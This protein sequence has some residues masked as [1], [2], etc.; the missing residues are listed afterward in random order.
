MSMDMKT[1]TVC[2]IMLIDIEHCVPKN[3]PFEQ[4]FVILLYYSSVRLD[5]NTWKVMTKIKDRS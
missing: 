5:N 1:T 4:I 2:T 3:V